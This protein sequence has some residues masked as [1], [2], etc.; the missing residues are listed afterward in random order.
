MESIFQD[1]M[2]EF[3]VPKWRRGAF[4]ISFTLGCSPKT[5]LKIENESNS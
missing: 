2:K 1:V 5:K 3:K 4:H